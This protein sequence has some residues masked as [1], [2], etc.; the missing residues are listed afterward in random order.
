MTMRVFSQLVS[1]MEMYMAI[2]A[3]MLL[4]RRIEISVVIF[5]AIYIIGVATDLML[6]MQMM[7]LT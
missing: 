2:S 5:M 3:K 6:S 1:F 7:K 4:P